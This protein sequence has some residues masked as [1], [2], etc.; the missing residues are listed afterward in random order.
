MSDD[1]QYN[2]LRVRDPKL[3]VPTLRNWSTW[4]TGIDV[5][6]KYT[7]VLTSELPRPALFDFLQF[8]NQV[9]KDAMEGPDAKTKSRFGSAPIHQARFFAA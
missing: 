8:F 4:Y 9:D 2:M 7:V 3:L 5:P 1:V 6:D